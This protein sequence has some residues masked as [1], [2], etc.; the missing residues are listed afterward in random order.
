MSTTTATVEALADAAVNAAAARA[1]RDVLREL[2]VRQNECA[3]AAGFG[4]DELSQRMT[5]KRSFSLAEFVDIASALGVRAPDLM[6]RVLSILDE[7]AG[8]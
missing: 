4:P 6:D 7:E 2:G 1:I 3:I 8:R 5:G